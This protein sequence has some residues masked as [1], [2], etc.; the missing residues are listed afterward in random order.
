MRPIEFLLKVWNHSC[1]EGDIVFLSTKSQGG[2]FQ[3]HPFEFKRGLRTEI[4]EWLKE[5]SSQ[6]YDLYFS[7][8]PFK[9]KRRKSASVRAVNLLWSDIDEGNPKKL[10][11]TIL[12]ESSPGRLQGLWIMDGEAMHPED[13]VQL[14]QALTYLLG[15]DKG[16]WDLARVL[17]IPG[18]HNHKYSSLPEV[19]M[20]EYDEELVYTQTALKRKLKVNKKPDTSNTVNIKGSTLSSDQVMSKYRRQ[21]PSKVKQL[22]AQKVVTKGKRSEIIWYLENKLSESGLSPE[23]ILVVIKASNW[24]KYKGRSDE[25][26]RLRTEMNK[27]IETKM[28]APSEK[29]SRDAANEELSTDLIIESMSDV[30]RSQNSMPGWLVEGFWLNQSHGIVAGQ[31]K[32]F[33]STLA[34]DLAISVASGKDFLDKYKVNNPGPVVYIQN[35]NAKWIMKD[36]IAKGLAYKKIIGSVDQFE[37]T[38][39]VKF[40][41]DLPLYM[42]NQQSFMLTDPMHQRQLDKIFEEIKPV[43]IIL[44]PLYLMFDGDINSAKELNPVLSWLMEM[45]FTHNCGMMLIH[46]YNKGGADN[47]GGQKMLGSTTLH[48]WT[49]SAWYISANGVTGAGDSEDEEAFKKS[50][51]GDITIER[52]FRG[53]GLHPKLD[54]E[55]RVGEFGSFDYGTEAKLHREGGGEGD[56]IKRKSQEETESS[57]MNELRLTKTGLTEAELCKRTGFGKPNIK[58]IVDVLVEK[59]IAKRVGK[60]VQFVEASK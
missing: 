10:K 40:V 28:E 4:R 43:L 45:R 35:E 46:H 42:I 5:H 14:N 44:D 19:R 31:P 23:E 26:E 58:N 20:L 53:A 7:P 6:E 38:L 55:I 54:V 57:I 37:D 41:D 13:A 50:V 52:E 15:A 48:G 8:L 25:E 3:N 16:C 27:I 22:L 33:K 24:N 49:E 11:P 29:E 18:T 59:G 9:N 34:L 1:E 12:W 17:R 47:R 36:R 21:I 32:S 30:M 56:T 39:K 2:G 60:T 51:K